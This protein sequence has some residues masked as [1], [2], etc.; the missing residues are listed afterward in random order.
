MVVSMKNAVFWD[1]M[2]CSC[3]KN[4]VS[5]ECIASVIRAIR[6]SE[7]GTKL[8]VTSLR[9]YVLPKRWFLEERH[10]ITSQKMAFFMLILFVLIYTQNYL[11]TSNNVSVSFCVIFIF[12]FSVID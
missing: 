6:I 5:E 8:A 4:D 12:M 7:L 11:L 9:Q 1:V 2:P 10:G 3:C